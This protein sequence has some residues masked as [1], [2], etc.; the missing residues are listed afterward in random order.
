[1]PIAYAIRF[2]V[3]VGMLC[4]LFLLCHADKAGSSSTHL[5]TLL[6][7][8]Y[9]S[10]ASTD[11][12]KRLDEANT[13]FEALNQTWNEIRDVCLTL[14]NYVDWRSFSASMK[15]NIK[16]IE[17]LKAKVLRQRREIDVMIEEGY[18]EDEC[19]PESDGCRRYIGSKRMGGAEEEPVYFKSSNHRDALEYTQMQLNTAEQ[20]LS[21]LLFVS[22][23]VNM[24]LYEIEC[25]NIK[26]EMKKLL[27]K[28]RK[29]ENTLI[30]Q[31]VFRKGKDFQ[32]SAYVFGVY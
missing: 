25:K 4:S 29:I 6:D 17:D 32:K 21:K 2:L 13:E 20:D 31:D 1:M 16:R 22:I 5:K 24:T 9:V 3:L 30:F 12:E 10:M 26:D 28:I 7:D 23:P 18:V 27:I 11:L 19:H 8:E 14:Q 15:K